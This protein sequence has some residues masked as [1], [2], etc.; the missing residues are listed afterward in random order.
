MA[1]EEELR[2]IAGNTAARVRQLIN[3][4]APA[5]PSLD[6]VAERMAVSKRTLARRL[7]DERISFQDLLDEA[8][9]ELASWYRSEEHTSELQ[10]H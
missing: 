5:W 2:R 8:K 9:N 4:E 1:G 10:S 7:S 6:Q 3:A